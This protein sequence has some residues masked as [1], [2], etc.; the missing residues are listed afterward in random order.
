MVSPVRVWDSP[1]AET[2]Q[3]GVG[4][5]DPTFRVLLKLSRDLAVPLPE[6]VEKYETHR[7][8]FELY[9]PASLGP[10]RTHDR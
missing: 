9:R 5:I 2:P 6:I 3:T 7:E 4:E 1:S 10:I 8:A